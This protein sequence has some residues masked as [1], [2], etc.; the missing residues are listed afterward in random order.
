MLATDWC[1]S[2]C[3]QATVS[4]RK[5]N[6]TSEEVQH[7]K[8]RM[9]A[10][11][12]ICGPQAKFQGEHAYATSSVHIAAYR[13][14]IR[15]LIGPACT[16]ERAFHD[17][18]SKNAYACRR[19]SKFAEEPG[20]VQTKLLGPLRGPDTPSGPPRS[21]GKAFFVRGREAAPSKKRL[22]TK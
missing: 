19:K 8:S 18:V 1:I 20:G 3:Q 2:Y 12:C 17:S 4:T 9:H 5:R 7:L 14:R 21:G 10:F 22:V 16:T 15:N 6:S 13:L 11:Q